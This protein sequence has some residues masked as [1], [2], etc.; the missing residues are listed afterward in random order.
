[1]PSVLSTDEARK[2]LGAVRT[3]QNS[4]YPTTVY[5]CG[6]RLNEA[7]NLQVSDIDSGRMHI[8]VHRGKGAKDRYVPLPEAILLSSCTTIGSP[9]LDFPK[10]RPKRQ[11]GPGGY[12]ANE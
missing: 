12:N 1:M 11:G 2:I 6:L 3:S 8:H 4:A 5:A 7:L 9:I 10:H